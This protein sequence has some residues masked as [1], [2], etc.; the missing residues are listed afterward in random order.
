MMFFALLLAFTSWDFTAATGNCSVKFE[1]CPQTMKV[2]WW[3]IPPYAYKKKPVDIKVT[4]IFK[5][6]VEKLVRDCCGSCVEFDYNTEAASNS[7]ILKSQIG[8]NQSVLAFPIYGSMTNVKFQNQPYFP[9]V[10]SPGVIYIQGTADSS[11]A[12]TAVMEAVLQGWPVLVLTLIMAALS[13]IVMWALDSYWNPDQFP[14]SFFHG[15]WEGFWW[16]FVS[17]TTV[18]YG[19]RAPKSFIARIFAFFWVLV[20]LVI[21]SIFTATVTTSLTALSLSNDITLYGSTI[22]ALENTEEQRYGVRNNAQ[23]KVRKTVKDFADAI[24]NDAEI[25][26]GL[27][28][29]YV[30]G[31]EKEQ[32]SE[33]KGLRVGTVFDHQFAYG[34]VISNKLAENADIERCLRRQLSTLESWITDQIQS[35]MTALPEPEKS[36]AEEK[37]S[38]LFD[39]KS[40]VFQN[41]VFTC[42]GLIGFLTVCGILWE[43]VYWRPKQKREQPEKA[44]P[45]R[46]VTPHTSFEELVAAQCQEL[47]DA[48]I[49]EVMAFYKAFNRKLE[50]IR[51]R[52]LRDDKLG[53]DKKDP[54]ILDL[55]D[56]ETMKM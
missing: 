49:T 44:D 53:I 3:N 30:A 15:A 4:G 13:G 42:L 7:E 12:A 38:N 2:N 18:G 32:L 25:T 56:P 9:V 24:I 27:I 40:E 22:V 47:E 34:F 41:A 26:G 31:Y 52:H 35:Q 8:E 6:I 28:D 46:V 10:E 54:E 20:G 19:D 14:S 43:Y 21:I 50:D 36:A 11:N 55:R 39:P 29:S 51:K 37:S 45:G 1:Q 33:D 48:M 17:M 5:T 16:A 23:V